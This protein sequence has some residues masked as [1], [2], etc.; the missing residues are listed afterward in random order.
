M[1]MKNVKDYSE[2]GKIK[3]TLTI[4]TEGRTIKTESITDI[5]TKKEVRKVVNVYG[6][7]RKEQEAILKKNNIK[8]D[9]K[10]KEADLV[11]KILNIKE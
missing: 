6:L 10:D 2:K 4:E 5:K 7:S 3:R 1:V 11:K 9:K 8:F